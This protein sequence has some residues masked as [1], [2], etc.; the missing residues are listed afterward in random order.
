MISYIFE[1]IS[2]ASVIIDIPKALIP[3]H[4]IFLTL[5]ASTH[6]SDIHTSPT[7]ILPALLP[8]L[9]LPP[10]TPTAPPIRTP[11]VTAAPMRTPMMTSMSM[12]AIKLILQLT[13]GHRTRDA[14]QEPMVPMLLAREMSHQPACDSTA[15]P[16]LAFGAGVGVWIWVVGVVRWLLLLM[17]LLLFT[18]VV[19]LSCW[20]RRGI[21]AIITLSVSTSIHIQERQGP[22]GALW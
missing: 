6:P 2:D 16:A 14:A 15:E 3:S 11:M 18:A 22:K 5:E 21:A 1:S 7:L 10:P 9:Y 19:L 12:L 20:R 8:R 13:P 4:I 17:L